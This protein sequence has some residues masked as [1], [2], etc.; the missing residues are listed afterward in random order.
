MITLVKLLAICLI[1]FGWQGP[2]GGSI[3]SSP[4]MAQQAHR[5]LFDKSTGV[6]KQ[7]SSYSYR[8]YRGRN[9]LKIKQGSTTVI[10]R[11][12]GPPEHGWLNNPYVK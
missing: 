1:S 12:H 7:P 11:W 6:T 3:R 5:A 10:R 4:T 8:H 2:G 9:E